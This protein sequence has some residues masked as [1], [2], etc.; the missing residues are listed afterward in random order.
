MVSVVSPCGFTRLGLDHLGDVIH[1]HLLDRDSRVLGDA[2]DVDGDRLARVT[3]LEAGGGTE[4]DA[5]RARVEPGEPVDTVG[6]GQSR[7]QHR[8]VLGE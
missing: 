2:L 7:D 8:A 3:E 6:P 4:L 1:H 5:V